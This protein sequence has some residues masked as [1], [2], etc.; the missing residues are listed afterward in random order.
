MTLRWLVL[1]TPAIYAGSVLLL[2]ELRW[3]RRPDL[4]ARLSPY[5][6]GHRLRAERRPWSVA[7]F[8]EVLAPLVTSAGD[9]VAGLF[10]T[11]EELG[12]RLRRIHSPVDVATFRLRQAGWVAAAFAGALLVSAV[13]AAPAPLALL[14]TLGVPTLAFLTIEQRVVATAVA[15]RRRV[16]LELPVVAEQLGM[17]TSAGWS[18]GA[19]LA[20][21]AR[22]GSG[23]CATDLQRVVH[24]I[25]QGLSDVDALREWAAIADIDEVDRLVSVLALN[26]ETADVGPLI[27]AEARSIRREAHRELV[28]AIERRTQQVWIPVTFAA[29]V[30]GVLLMGVPFVD[31]LSLFSG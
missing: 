4:A 9:R 5:A 13:A 23:A 28:E 20:R 31:A 26:R 22:H 14:A 29:L 10:G 11:G 15:W 3:F 18:V 12:A 19:A 24:R 21:I 16:F 7:S 1:T 2:A 27:A 17:L 30:P 25:G 8:H 6:P